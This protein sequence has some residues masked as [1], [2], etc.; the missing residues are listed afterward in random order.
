MLTRRDSRGMVIFVNNRLVS[1]KKLAG[2][3]KASFRTLLEVGRHPIGALSI[4]IAPD[5]VDVNVHPRKTEVRFTNERRVLSHVINLLSTFLSQTPWLASSTSQVNFS[6]RP[7][8]PSASSWP[9]NSSYDNPRASYD[10]LLAAPSNFIEAQAATQSLLPTA[11]F[12]ELRVIG[13][14]HTTYLLLE[15]HEGLVVIDQHA[16]HER[17]S[18]ERIR[19]ARDPSVITK[20]LLIPMSF[21]V[22]R[23][24]LGL[25]LDHLIDFRK[26]RHRIRALWRNDSSYK[27]RS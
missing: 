10:F 18:F 8:L 26:T 3:I 27:S 11:K 25:I 7:V 6:S 21:E 23:A 22:S 20:T 5:E 17:I 4:G 13:Q 15:S 16:A 2:A 12:S 19:A 14:V 1:D 9:Q 24:D